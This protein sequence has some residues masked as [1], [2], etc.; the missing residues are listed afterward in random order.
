MILGSKGD[1]TLA[2]FSIRGRVYKD[3]HIRQLK[4]EIYTVIYLK[5]DIGVKFIQDVRTQDFLQITG[6]LHNVHQNSSD[7]YQFELCVKVSIN[8]W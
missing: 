3:R 8:I 4:E 2:T 7:P 1:S 6:S 5:E